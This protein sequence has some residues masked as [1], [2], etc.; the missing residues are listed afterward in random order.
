MRTVGRAGLVGAERADAAAPPGGAGGRD[1]FEEFFRENEPKLR[2]ALAAAYGP[3]DGREAAA[4]ALAY[5]WEHWERLQEVGNL[6]GYLFRVAQSRRRRRRVPV[7]SDVPGGP[8][9]AS[10]PA[11]PGRWPPC[12]SGSGWQSCSSTATAARCARCPS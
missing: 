6:P 5:A 7:L 9:T 12:R 11:C 10:S 8:S 2:R 4:E 1:T 3:E